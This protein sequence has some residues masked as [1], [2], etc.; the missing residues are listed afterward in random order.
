[1]KS[2]RTVAG[3]SHSTGADADPRRHLTG[4]VQRRIPPIRRARS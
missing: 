3:F 1:M 4:G 2:R